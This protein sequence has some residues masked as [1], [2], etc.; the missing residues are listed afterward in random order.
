MDVTV[1][2]VVVAA[3]ALACG[4]AAGFAARGRRPS[5]GALPLERLEARLDVQTSEVRRL[6]DAARAGDAVSSQVGGHV[7]A[8][9][10]AARESLGRLAVGEQ[11]RLA[12]EEETV[13]MIKRLST[14]LGGGQ[15]KG[16]AGE[17]V[18]RAQLDAL[19]PGMLG[20]EFRVNGKVV[21]Y[22]LELPDG[23]RLPV[24]SKWSGDAELAALEGA[25]EGDRE[26]CERA[27][28]RIV[29]LRAKE[30]AAYLDPALTAPVAV[31]AV[32]DAAYAVL[33]RAHADAFAKG[34]VIV[35]YSTAMPTLL[36]L[37]SLVSRF[38]SVG[39]VRAC[40]SELS[41]VFDSIESV[42][43]NKLARA[44]TMLTNG[45]DEM[46]SHVGK[47]RGS[48]ARGRGVQTA[49][50][51]ASDGQIAAEALRLEHAALRAVE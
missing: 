18:L 2:I 34:V 29:A 37:H 6:A 45:N 19:P 14:V 50:L 9:L 20:I 5:A 26:Q 39:D 21:E 49:A 31:A 8:Q 28:E 35:P 42:L 47:A 22:S 30:V 3:V 1:L 51:A 10:A 32:P 13:Q 48:L 7:A 25:D 17:N 12:R 27:V 40:L 38:G 41:G 46:R 11:Q 43:E 4:A 23:R 16:R 44:V 24:D 15:S 36:F 33:R